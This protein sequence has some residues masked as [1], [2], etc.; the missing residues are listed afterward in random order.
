[1]NASLTEMS[2]IFAPAESSLGT[3]ASGGWRVGKEGRAL[4]GGLGGSGGHSELRRTTRFQ[5]PCAGSLALLSCK[6]GSH[7]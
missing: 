6:K 4:Q 3:E 7:H 2:L 1:M 5:E